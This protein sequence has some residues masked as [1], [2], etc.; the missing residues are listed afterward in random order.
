M[1]HMAPTHVSTIATTIFVYKLK[2]KVFKP[3]AT[4]TQ[5]FMY[6]NCRKVL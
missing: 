5:F 2:A 3:V 4:E 1:G 6:Q